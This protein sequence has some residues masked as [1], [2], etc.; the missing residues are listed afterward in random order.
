MPETPSSDHPVSPQAVPARLATVKDAI[1]K[2]AAEAGRKA[3]DITLTAVTKKFSAEHIRPALEAGH[4]TFGENRVQEAQ[5]KWPGLRDE[6]EDVRLHLIGPLQT[7]KAE[8]AV[9]LFDLI[10]TLDREKL[11]RALAKAMDKTGQAPAGSRTG[12][13]RRG[14]TKGRHRADGSAV[15]HRSVSGGIW[16]AGRWRHVHSANRRLPRAAFRASS[17]DCRGCRP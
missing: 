4:R 13:Y 11:A 16:T 12:Q 9:A 1:A 3:A 10:E 2:A 5:G 8:D 17:Q 14:R 15:L 6:Y 7:N